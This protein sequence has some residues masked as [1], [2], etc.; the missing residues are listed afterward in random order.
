MTD[1]KYNAIPLQYQQDVYGVQNRYAWLATCLMLRSVNSNQGQ[2]LLDPYKNNP[3]DFEWLRI[4]NKNTKPGVL[5][6]M[7]LLMDE[8][9]CNHQVITLKFSNEFQKTMPLVDFV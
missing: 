8:E 1:V 4:R 3:S 2:Y 6:L 9:L 7:T 5:T